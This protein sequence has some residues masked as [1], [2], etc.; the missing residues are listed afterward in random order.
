M[1][2]TLKNTLRNSNQEST[3]SSQDNLNSERAHSNSDANYK[4]EKGHPKWYKKV[5]VRFKDTL[6]NMPNFTSFLEVGLHKSKRI[7]EKEPTI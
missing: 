6:N 3:D 1:I 7:A 5:L 4:R 2:F